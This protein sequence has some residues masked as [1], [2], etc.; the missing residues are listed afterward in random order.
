MENVINNSLTI[1]YIIENYG[2]MVSAICRRMIQNKDN[3]EDA[4]Q[5]VWLEVSKSLKNFR[6]ES[7]ITTWLYTIAS[8]VVMK[9]AKEEHKYSLHFLS[10]YYHGDDIEAPD[11]D[12]FDKQLWVREMCD[13]CLTGTLHCLDNES[14]MAY[15][16]RDINMVPYADIAEIL[17]RDE[18]GVRKM[19]S[20]SRN[21]LRNFLNDEC[22]LKNPNAKCKCRMSKWVKEVHLQEEYQKLSQTVNKINLYRASEII[23]TKNNL[24]N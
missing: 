10:S 21:K 3:V 4:T 17:E 15:I 11:Y 12:D 19:V 7:K 23:L 1:E 20:R 18:A 2:K 13:K 24:I 9:M 14:R 5:E 16:L 6:G 8:R 22:I